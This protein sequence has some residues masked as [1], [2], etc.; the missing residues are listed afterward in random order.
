M[1]EE[2]RVRLHQREVLPHHV[3]DSSSSSVHVE[4]VARLIGD[5]RVRLGAR[6]PQSG[7]VSTSCALA[8]GVTTVVSAK[9][10]VL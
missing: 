8:L 10:K 6:W 7:P 9:K 5:Q 2:V 4:I 3:V 1:D